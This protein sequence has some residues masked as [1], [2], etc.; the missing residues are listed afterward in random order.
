MAH[1]GSLVDEEGPFDI[2]THHFILQYGLEP[3]DQ[4][5][6]QEH[7]LAEAL[8]LRECCSRLPI[9]SSPISIPAL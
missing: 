2:G 7:A 1:A 9:I 8:S 4:V 6:I 3:T 5:A